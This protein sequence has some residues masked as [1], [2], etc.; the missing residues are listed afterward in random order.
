MVDYQ[1][2]VDF[3]VVEG[4]RFYT[5]FDVQSGGEAIG[6]GVPEDRNVILR[7]AWPQYLADAL[8]VLPHREIESLNFET[9]Q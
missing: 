7:F 2:P 4:G 1:I 9:D 3:P 8:A 5:L 6:T